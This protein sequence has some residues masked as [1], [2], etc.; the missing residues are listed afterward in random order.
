MVYKFNRGNEKECW[1]DEKI[2]KKMNLK[3][4]EFIIYRKYI[5]NALTANDIY[6]Y[7]Q[8]KRRVSLN[9]RYLDENFAQFIEKVVK[10]NIEGKCIKEGYVVPNTTVI[11]KRSMGNLN[12]NQFNGN[13]NFDLI[14]GAK[15][16]N[17]PSQSV[18]RAQVKKINKLGVLAELGPLMILVPKDMHQAKDP[19]KDIKP[20]QEIELLVVGKS[21]DLNSKVISVFAK[22]NSEV[23]K[24]FVVPVR[25]GA[26]KHKN[27]IKFL[28]S[29]SVLEENDEVLSDD[30][31]EKLDE[32]DEDEDEEDEELSS[33]DESEELDVELDAELI[34]NEDSI[35]VDAAP[36]EALSEVSDDEE[37]DDD[38]EE[39]EDE[40][41]D[42]D[43]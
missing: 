34:D 26:D 16:C 36:E 10:N 37:D 5:M 20:G 4:I 8:I 13:I 15:I 42:Y 24:K 6:F 12:N 38:D 3:V 35:D 28:A 25:K 31:A 11:L 41:I 7:T 33:G 40:D 18:I 21:F 19:F 39:E 30:S 1:M 2:M 43:E 17:I 14:I 29:E 32:D 22:L 23:K 9:P 27:T